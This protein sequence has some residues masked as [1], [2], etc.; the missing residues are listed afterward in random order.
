MSGRI[1]SSAG[2]WAEAAKRITGN[3]NLGPSPPLLLPLPLRPSLV[4]R[5][6]AAET[7]GYCELLVKLRCERDRVSIS[8]RPETMGYSLLELY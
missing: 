6:R 8:F 7:R 1:G 5:L 3:G 2:N 4:S